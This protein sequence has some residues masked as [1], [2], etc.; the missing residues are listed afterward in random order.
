MFI[1]NHP[2]LLYVTGIQCSA[3]GVQYPRLQRGIRT[4]VIRLNLC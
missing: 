3:I 4:G 2:Y 1:F